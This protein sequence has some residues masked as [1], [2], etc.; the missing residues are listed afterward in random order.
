MRLTLST[1]YALRTLIYLGAKRG[2]AAT[3]AEIAS[4]FGISRAHLVKIVHRLGQQGYLDT[5]RG[6]GGGIRLGRPATEIR[7]GAVVRDTE[8]DLAVMGC[9]EGPGFCRIERCCVLR[10]ALSDATRAFLA[11]LDGFTLQDL[12]SPAATLTR[13]LGLGR[14]RQPPPP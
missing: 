5:T 7:V 9:L 11:T 10:Q 4:A 8:D 1:D 14:G 13:N 6:R 3:I 12:L 2:E